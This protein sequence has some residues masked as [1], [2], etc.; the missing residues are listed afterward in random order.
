MGS[1]TNRRTTTDSPSSSSSESSPGAA[2]LQEDALPELAVGGI[3]T[4][5]IAE[6]LRDK[7]SALAPS[8]A[9]TLERVAEQARQAAPEL[10]PD[11]VARLVL[12][13]DRLTTL[14]MVAEFRQLPPSELA[15]LVKLERAK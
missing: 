14:R 1:Q 8:L 4:Q 5:S 11:G 9:L 13:V 2:L 6:V 7:P 12:V 10:D 15:T 3:T